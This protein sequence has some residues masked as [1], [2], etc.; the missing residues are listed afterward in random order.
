MAPVEAFGVRR[1]D[2]ATNFGSGTT[3]WPA[4]E[5]HRRRR[6]PGLRSATADRPRPSGALNTTRRARSTS[7]NRDGGVPRMVRR[8]PQATGEPHCQEDGEQRYRVIRLVAARMLLNILIY[9]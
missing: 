8:A 9:P 6:Y 5:H 4:G 2:P 7:R 1:R 3:R